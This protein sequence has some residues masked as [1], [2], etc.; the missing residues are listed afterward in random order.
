MI[1]TLVGAAAVVAILSTGADSLQFGQRVPLP[2]DQRATVAEFNQRI[3]AYM[4]LRAEVGAAVL[5]IEV[6]SDIDQIQRAVDK[7]AIGIRVARAGRPQG[8]IFSPEIA[9]LFRRVIRTTCHD[10]FTDLLALIHEDWEQP[11]PPAVVHGRWPDGVPVPSM[12]PDLLAALPNLPPQLEYRFI[13]RDLVVRDIDAN[14]IL[15][16]VPEAI[17]SATWTMTHR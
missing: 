1:P 9:A 2:N 4:D 14:L 12:P 17:P 11:L 13:N 6:T 7:L 10:R 15:D 5:P 16:F 3:Q 8:A